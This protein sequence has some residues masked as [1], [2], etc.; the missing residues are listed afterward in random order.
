MKRWHAF[1]GILS[2]TL[3]QTTEVRGTKAE[4]YDQYSSTT[5]YATFATVEEA[6]AY[7]DSQPEWRT[8]TWLIRVVDGEITTVPAQSKGVAVVP[9][10]PLPLFTEPAKVLTTRGFWDVTSVTTPPGI[11]SNFAFGM[12]FLPV[13][14]VYA[15]T[16][17]DATRIST[18]S[19][20]DAPDV[21][22]PLLDDPGWFAYD[23]F[24]RV[25]TDVNQDP[26]FHSK[27]QRKFPAN[28][29]LCVVAGTEVSVDNLSSLRLNMGIRFRILVEH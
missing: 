25:T 11:V 5:V 19:L 20:R 4:I 28:S 22:D 12:I 10:T 21:P 7:R 9:I 26:P 6:E 8:T 27:S 18:Y 29:V 14:V 15:R 23:S 2:R 17:D 1:S 13:S 16:R 3:S 24:V